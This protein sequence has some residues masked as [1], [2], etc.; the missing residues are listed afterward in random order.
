M[1]SWRDNMLIIIIYSHQEMH[2]K[3]TNIS[4]SSADNKWQLRTPS[5]T[6]NNSSKSNTEALCCVEIL[7]CCLFAG[8][9]ISLNH[10]SVAHSRPTSCLLGCAIPS[11]FARISNYLCCER[12]DCHMSNIAHK[13]HVYWHV[14]VCLLCCPLLSR[15]WQCDY[16][17]WHLLL[18]Y[19]LIF[20]LNGVLSGKT[21]KL[22]WTE[23]IS[24]E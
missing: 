1:S 5:L 4:I 20:K 17:V 2:I 9:N 19:E 23:D 12:Y 16:K 21:G 7:L 13:C 14:H 15:Q 22:T 11:T 18:T 10:F 24:I 8:Q 6:N 3:S